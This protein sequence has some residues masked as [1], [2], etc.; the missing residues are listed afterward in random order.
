M[1]SRCEQASSQLEEAG[2]GPNELI[3]KKDIH[4]P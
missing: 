3:D 2:I 1:K 4:I